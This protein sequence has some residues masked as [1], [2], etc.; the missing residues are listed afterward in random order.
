MA[1]YR[2]PIAVGHRE[3]AASALRRRPSVAEIF[4]IEEF[5]LL[6]EERGNAPFQGGDRRRVAAVRLQHNIV[7]VDLSRTE[8]EGLQD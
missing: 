4:Q 5:L 7:A 8:P 3:T 2:G 6:E 1:T